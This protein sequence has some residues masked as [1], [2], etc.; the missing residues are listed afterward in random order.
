MLLKGAAT[1]G[2]A[3]D[4]FFIM[5]NGSA[6]APAL[7]SVPPPPTRSGRHW[8]RIIDTAAIPPL[9]INLAAK[10]SMVRSGRHLSV[11]AM[12]CVVLQ[13]ATLQGVKSRRRP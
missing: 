9:D 4:D 2:Q 8:R 5:L 3:E 10:G 11:P 13:T 6:N 7:F 12:A 1:P